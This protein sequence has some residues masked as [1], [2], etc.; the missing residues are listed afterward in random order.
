MPIFRT[1][2]LVNRDGINYQSI[3]FRLNAYQESLR[4]LTDLCQHPAEFAHAHHPVVPFK[5]LRHDGQGMALALREMQ[6]HEA[7]SVHAQLAAADFHVHAGRL[8]E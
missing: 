4:I 2:Q 6:P 7:D 1:Q 8:Q 5:I 3:H